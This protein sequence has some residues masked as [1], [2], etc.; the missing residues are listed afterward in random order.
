MQGPC[1]ASGELFPRRMHCTAGR[2]SKCAHMVILFSFL[3][4]IGPFSERAFHIQSLPYPVAMVNPRAPPPTFFP[5]RRAARMI[6]SLPTQSASAMSRR[7]HDCTVTHCTSA[8]DR[9]TACT[10]CTSEAQE[11]PRRA[12]FTACP[13]SCRPHGPYAPLAA[14]LYGL[15]GLV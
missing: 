3:A 13:S 2:C 1:R 9:L 12:R 11:A 7:L 8:T 15:G 5:R 4:Q 10:R 14:K 6:A